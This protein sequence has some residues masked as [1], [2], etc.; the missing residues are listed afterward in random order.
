MA[1]R[2]TMNETLSLLLAW[3]TGIIL[4][5][6]FFGGLWWTI[7]KGLSSKRSALWFFVSVILRASVVLAGF[8]FIE[9][10]HWE[11][12]LVCLL[13]FV[14]ARLVVMRLT[15]VYE[16]PAALSREAGHAS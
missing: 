7:Q 14:V 3:V 6:F 16:K 1:E 15:R 5:L 13:G 2:N 11:R 4:G 8:Y 10:G 12:L 9:R